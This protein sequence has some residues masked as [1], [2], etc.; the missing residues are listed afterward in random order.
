MPTTVGARPVRRSS[1]PGAAWSIGTAAAVLVLT[2]AGCGNGGVEPV[3]SGSPTDGAT[4]PTVSVAASAA[5]ASDPAAARL[6]AI[7]VVELLVAAVNAGEFETAWDLLDDA[8]RDAIGDPRELAT[9]DRQLVDD[10]RAA[11]RLDEPAVF[12]AEVEA[13]SAGAASWV[14]TLRGEDAD[15]AASGPRAQALLVTVG[16]GD[17]GGGVSLASYDTCAGHAAIDPESGAVDPTRSLIVDLPPGATL[18]YAALDEEPVEQAAGGTLYRLSAITAPEPG[19]H[20]L[21]LVVEC[22]GVLDATA[23]TYTFTDGD[24]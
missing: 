24:G 13:T 14:V 1:R 3:V 9:W 11:A 22:E 21:T 5:D 17:G 8:T 10:L 18:R 7:E 12:A 4:A 19:S 16:G 2:A 23:R 6:A 20:A 15:P